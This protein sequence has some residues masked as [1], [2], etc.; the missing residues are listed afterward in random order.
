MHSFLVTK[1]RRVYRFI[2]FSTVIFVFSACSDRAFQK[3][4]ITEKIDFITEDMIE[5]TE[6]TDVG[7]GGDL[8]QCQRNPPKFLFGFGEG[9]YTLDYAEFDKTKVLYNMH[10]SV[11]A[12]LM[13]VRS[14]LA[15]S[16]PELLESFDTFLQSV[17]FIEDFQASE[18][19]VNGIVRSWIANEQ[20]EKVNDEDPGFIPSNCRIPGERTIQFHQVVVRKEKVNSESKLSSTTYY[21]DPLLIEKLKNKELQISMLV[22]HEWLWDLF[23]AHQSKRLRIANRLLHSQIKVPTQILRKALQLDHHEQR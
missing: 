15:H 1:G 7:N 2:F 12:H 22:V 16:A 3:S 18:V 10:Q 13:G 4:E 19:K 20:N 17:P 8:I 14:V 9:W 23:E 11:K 21:Y 5:P 6:G